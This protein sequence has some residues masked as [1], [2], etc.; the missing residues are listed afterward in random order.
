MYRPGIGDVEL[1][2]E[3][4]RAL[5]EQRLVFFC[6]AGISVYT[7]LRLFKGL[8]EDVFEKTCG[9]IEELFGDEL[10]PA[11]AAFAVNQYDRVLGLLEQALTPG[12]MRHA[13]IEELSKEFH[14]D[15]FLHKAILDLAR[16]PEGG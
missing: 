9:P 12:T 15:L 16:V 4:E 11:Q 10:E 8:V 13:V 5:E 1:P 7:D 3:I 14:G 2:S 6:G